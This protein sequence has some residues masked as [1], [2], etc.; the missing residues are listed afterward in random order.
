MHAVK[1][2]GL[3]LT[4]LL[5][6]ACS[7]TQPPAPAASVVEDGPRARCDKVLAR[8]ASLVVA[9]QE[10]GATKAEDEAALRATVQSPEARAQCE[11]EMDDET[12]RCA[13][14]ANDADALE[15]CLERK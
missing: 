1:A 14:S 15:R 8:Y 9:A 10:A 12:Y 11:A 7:K 5:C 4:A 6:A 3:A 2:F 13:V